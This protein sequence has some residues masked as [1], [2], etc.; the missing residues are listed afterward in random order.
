MGVVVPSWRVYPLPASLR[1][2]GETLGIFLVEGVALYDAIQC[3]RNVVGLLR[4]AHRLRVVFV[5]ADLLRLVFVSLC[6]SF[7]VLFVGLVVLQPQLA[8]CIVW[9]LS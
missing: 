7:F 5:F 6:S 4:R 1:M 9:L 3:A 2:L 8:C